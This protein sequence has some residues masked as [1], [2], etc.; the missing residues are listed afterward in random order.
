MQAT[1]T[2]IPRYAGLALGKH[3]FDNAKRMHRG[4]LRLAGG[5][6]HEDGS[7]RL[8]WSCRVSVVAYACDG[9]G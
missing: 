2:R 1:P 6:R 5:Q 3:I 7:Q 8:F 9:C 4:R